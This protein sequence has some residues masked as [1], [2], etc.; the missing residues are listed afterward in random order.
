MFI[1]FWRREQ[2]KLQFEWDTV[3]YS[4]NETIRPEFEIQ[5]KRKREN[6]ITKKTEPYIPLFEKINRYSLSVATTAFVMCLVLAAVLGIIVYRVSLRIV[7]SKS[8][9]LRHYSVY[10]VTVSAGLI[11][12]IAILALKHFY[13]W[14]AVKLTNLESH[15]YNSNYENSLTIK[16]YLFQFINYYSAVFYIAFIKGR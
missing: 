15:K 7:L 3:N 4:R 12:L 11:N 16:M 2:H 6:P 9:T 8:D 10:I 5:T 14:L 1:A 13:R